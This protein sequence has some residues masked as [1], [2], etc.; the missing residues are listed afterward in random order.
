MFDKIDMHQY[1]I[2]L[3]RLK[4]YW[5]PLKP[6]ERN[7]GGFRYIIVRVGLSDDVES[8]R[9]NYNPKS[10]QNTTLSILRLSKTRQIDL[11]F[12]K[13]S[14]RIYSRYIILFP[15]S[16]FISS[17]MAKAIEISRNMRH[18]HSSL[19]ALGID[20]KVESKASSIWDTSVSIP[21]QNTNYWLG[22]IHK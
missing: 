5:Q 6:W 13:K 12:E 22:A 7:G 11:N 14:P 19:D 1:S 15:T 10:N 8:G 18:R 4:L 17:A 16:T 9:H 2:M 21:I 20:G 3:N